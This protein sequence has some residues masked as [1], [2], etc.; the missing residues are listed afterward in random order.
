MHGH[1]APTTR[2]HWLRATTA[3]LAL[4]A[5][6][7]AGGCATRTGMAV[8][9]RVAAVGGL[10][11]CGVWPRVAAAAEAALGQAVQTVATAPKEGVVPAFAQGAAVVLLIHASDEATSLEAAGLASPP[12]V[13]GWNEHVL[14]GPAH[15]PAGVR[16]ASD[17]TEALRRIA[18]AQAPFIALR[19]AGSYT[20]VQRLWRRGGIRPDARWLRA[21]TSAQPQ[22]VLQQAA[23]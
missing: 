1:H 7:A 23:E 6:L 21:D 16:G 2:R 4:P 8:P 15:D 19:D 9:V 10:S 3:A 20:I 14:V 17:G 12:R 11:L 13:W 18:A 22:A 5:W